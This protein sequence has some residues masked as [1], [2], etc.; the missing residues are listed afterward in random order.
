VHQLKAAHRFYE[1]NNFTPIAV[2][3]LP[4]Y[5]PLML[6]DNMFYQLHLDKKAGL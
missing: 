5:F 2:A 3:D 6:T 1:R 4:T